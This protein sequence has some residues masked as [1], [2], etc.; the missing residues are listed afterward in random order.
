MDLPAARAVV[1]DMSPKQALQIAG[2]SFSSSYQISVKE[3]P[4]WNGR[5]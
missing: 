5:I 3:I 1:L 2:N 4:V